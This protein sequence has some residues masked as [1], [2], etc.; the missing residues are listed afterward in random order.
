[1][2]ELSYNYTRISKCIAELKNRKLKCRKFKEMQKV[3][4]AKLKHEI[5]KEGEDLNC[6]KFQKRNC[7]EMLHG[8]ALEVTLHS[9]QS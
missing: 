2:T 4:I 5:K 6:I 3:K 8:G 1:M 7:T 9:Q